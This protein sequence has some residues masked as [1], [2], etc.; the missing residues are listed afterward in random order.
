MDLFQ[1]KNAFFSL[2]LILPDKSHLKIVFLHEKT[3]IWS[4]MANFFDLRDIPS[5]PF[6]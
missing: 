2:R 6:F 3:L 4:K 5:F 1:V